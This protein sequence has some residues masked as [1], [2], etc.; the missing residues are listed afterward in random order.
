MNLRATRG[1]G[2]RKGVQAKLK[3][4]G[5]WIL[6]PVFALSVVSSAFPAKTNATVEAGLNVT[7][8]DNWT[9]QGN[10]YNNAP[11]IP[12]TT[13]VCLET[14]APNI[15]WDFDQVPVCGIYE[16]FV[17]KFEG[18]I[19]APETGTYTF[20]LR[21]DD[22][23]RLF[24]GNQMVT[25]FWRDTG[26][27][28][29]TFTYTLNAG[30][31]IPILAWYYE[32]GGGAWV[33]MRYQVNGEWTPVPAAWFTKTAAPTTTTT[34]TIAPY[35][36]SP[37]NLTVTST[38]ETKVYLEWDAPE[39][40]NADVERYAIFFSKDNFS[41][42]WAITSTQTTAVVENLDPDTEY[43][44]KVRADN[45]TI[46]VYSGWSNEVTATTDAPP[47]TYS[48]T[49]A[50][51]ERVNEGAE[52]TLS[53]P[54]GSVFTEVLFASYGTPTGSNGLYR[55]S[56]CNSSTS[57]Q[58]VSAVFIGKTSAT[59]N[60]DN[61]VFGDPCG[62]TY[63]HLSVVLRYAPLPTTTTT[64][65]EPPITTTTTEVPVETPPSES[66]PQDDEPSTSVPQ[67]APE[68]ET[69]T[70]VA[71]EVDAAAEEILANADNPEELG[72]AVSDAV[73]NTDS[74]EELG[75]LVSSLL[76]KPLS[77]EEFAAV[78]DSVF[79][80]DLSTEEL[81]AA[82]DAVFEE[83]LSD[84]KFAEAI[85][86]VLDNPLTDEQFAAVVDVLESDS[87]SEEQVASAVDT[88]LENGVTEDQA[89]S[90]ASSEKVLESIDAEQAT[91]IFE[92]IPVDALS[93][94]EEAALVAAVTNAPEEVK[95][96]FEGAIDIY[97]EGLDDYVPVGSA[98][99]VE[100]RRSLIAVTTVM[101]A[102]AATGAAPGAGGGPSGGN[103]S[104]GSGGSPSDSNKAARK[105][106]EQ[107]DEEAGGLE[108]PEDREKNLNTRNS[109]YRY[110]EDGL[111]EFSVMGFIKKF[112]K[113][114]AALSFTFAG[115]AI[116]FVTLSGDTRRIAI[117][118]TA[119]AVFVH[120]VHVM[121]ENDEE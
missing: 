107:E 66:N 51:W 118:A 100:T 120:Y 1:S 102:V 89:T 86:A 24:F 74:P 105:E 119:A 6:A 15:N 76:D 22:G 98:V 30:E 87:V 9:G 41:S 58:E 42:G 33:R 55:T 104:G 65:T 108:G 72:A 43:Q 54:N 28:G 71:P 93:P 113:E 49:N 13:P 10:A 115:S 63:K 79:S 90:L 68:Q 80:E 103:G 73:A 46:P 36:N 19:T 4:H 97:G 61:G 62:G 2:W 109:I 17:V 92:E 59:I 57:I 84:E 18:F 48:L 95:G 44:F 37:Q 88:I 99:D 60:A 78:I 5:A 35:L 31:S 23:T 53:A 85:D 16:D 32:N 45:D 77:T 91:D 83:P 75:A 12:P 34:T 64:T 25:N 117:I 56:Q 20:D 121:L 94:E 101:S 27:G 110:S 81:S 111:K 70:T 26:N 106:N 96:A 112:L 11:P 39:F 7:V 3:R 67:Y 82:L 21:G 50:V 69:P 29:E 40:S 38:N 114:T 116:M 52:L 47:I 8:Y 14:T